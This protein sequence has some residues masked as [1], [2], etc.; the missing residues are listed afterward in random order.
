MIELLQGDCIDVLPTI[1]AGS[2]QCAV[3]SPPYYGLRAYSDDPREIGRESTPDCM[4]WARREVSCGACYVCALRAVFAQ[5]WRVLRDDGTAWLNLGDSMAG[6]WGNYGSRDGKQ[7]GERTSAEWVRPAYDGDRGFTGKPGTARVPGIKDK[8][9]LMIPARVALALQADGWIVRSDVIWSKPNCMPESVTDRPTRAHEYVFLLAKQAR[10]YYDATAIAEAATH[11]G[12]GTIATPDKAARA[13]ITSNG[14]GATTLR[15]KECTTR[16]RR[17]VWSIA[18]QPFSG[19]HFATMPEALIEPCI[20]AGSSAQ[21]CEH[22]GA[23][24]GR[25]V[26]RESITQRPRGTEPSQSRAIG[27]SQQAGV[28]VNVTDLGFAPRCAC[29]DNTGSARSTVL[30][31][32]AGSGTVLRVAQRF[33][34]NAIGIDLNAAY[35]DLQEKRTDGAQIEMFV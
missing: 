28:Y 18:T 4:A 1:A 2:V 12:G 3:T 9:L 31:P 17:T 19:A 15:G 27:Q 24:W 26:E 32:F 5:L 22:C 21:A 10:Y 8:N 13:G 34:R 11:T 30:D 14:T 16:N 6:S 20:L 23:A 33:Q 35:I 7:R 25:V 29:P